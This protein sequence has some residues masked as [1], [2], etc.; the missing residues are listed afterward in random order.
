MWL[1]KNILTSHYGSISV[2]S[3][4]LGKGS[5]FTLKLPSLFSTTTTRPN[6]IEHSSFDKGL[7]LLPIESTIQKKIRIL[8]A[9]DSKMNRKI[10][11]QLFGSLKG[12]DHECHE[13][14]DGSEAITTIIDSI[15]NNNPFDLILMDYIM[16]TLNGPEAVKRIRQ[17]LKFQ[18]K[19][20]G[21]TGNAFAE[22]LNTF[23]N[24]GCSAVYV[25]PINIKNIK[26][27]L[28]YVQDQ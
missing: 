15:K 3:D 7:D 6:T 27:I 26:E 8:I 20:I 18:G 9:D 12:L 2:H 24:A 11:K 10:L 21:L 1:C 28:N 19:I 25:K 23:M 4:G 5:S 14:S 22:D 16:I 17:E 13:C